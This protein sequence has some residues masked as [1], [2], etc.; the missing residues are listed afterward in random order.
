[1][2]GIS[3]IVA[4]YNRKAELERLLK[5]LVSNNCDTLEVIIV[6]QNKNNLIDGL[7]NEYSN[8][9]SIKHIK[10]DVPNQSMARNIG[11]REAKYPIICFPDDDCWFEDN[12]LNGIIKYFREN[13][14]TDLL[15]INWN[16]NVNK[17]S[18]SLRFTKRLIYSFRAPMGY[19]TYVIVFKKDAFFRLGCFNETIGLGQYIGSGEDSELIFRAAKNNLYIFHDT[20]IKVNHKYTPN[21]SRDLTSIRSRQRGIGYIYSKYLLFSFV[22]VRGLCSPLLSSLFCFDRKKT[23]AHF[24]TFL[25][26]LE[27][28]S[29]GFKN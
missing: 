27:G 7:I 29:Y 5:S 1:M 6:D 24:Y 2:E 28:L 26:R 12:A 3:A 22:P 16:Q 19:N 14:Q 4:T 17:A 8:L 20:T 9:L 11:A 21:L 23:R 13:S 18:Q 15:I 25:G 10:I